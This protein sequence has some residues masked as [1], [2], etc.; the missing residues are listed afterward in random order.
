MSPSGQTSD[1]SLTGGPCSVLVV[2][3]GAPE[4]GGIPTFVDGLLRPG[5]FRAGITIKY[6]NTTR[7]GTQRTGAGSPSAA[8][9]RKTLT[10]TW[11]TFVRARGVDIVHLHTSPLPMGPLLRAVWPSAPRV[12]WPVPQWCVTCMRASSRELD[13]SVPRGGT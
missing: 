8:N 6:L 7:V 13:R 1:A 12:G 9:V 2:A 3:Q 4:I 5:F 10:D 11:R